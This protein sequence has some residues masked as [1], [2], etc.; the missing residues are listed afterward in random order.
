MCTTTW[1]P[2]FTW[3][4]AS[5]TASTTPAPSWPITAGDGHWIVPSSRLTS[6]WH[7]PA[8]AMRTRTSV[9]PGGLTS[10]SSRTDAFSPSKTSAFI[11]NTSLCSW[12]RSTR[13]DDALDL[14][15]RV[16]AEVAAVAADAA[17]LEPAERRLVVAL[18]GV[19]A[20]V[21]GFELLRDAVGAAR[22][23]RR[24]RSRRGRSR[25][26]W[27]PRSPP[28]RSRPAR[29]RSPDR[30]SPRAP[31]SSG[32]CNPRAASGRRSSR[33]RRRGRRPSTRSSPPSSTPVWIMVSMRPR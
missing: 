29:R 30:R 22:C 13:P 7:S 21:A 10:T 2:G 9:G 31:A 32:S 11:G 20:H 12:G 18:G 23:P 15:V 14:G 3:V 8:D 27:R 26:R 1:S 19:D 24:T 6:E 25:N 16:E 4:T 17:H 33:A 5:P 28:R